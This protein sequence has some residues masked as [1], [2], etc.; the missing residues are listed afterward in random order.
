[1]KYLEQFRFAYKRAFRLSSILNVL[2]I[3]AAVVGLWQTLASAVELRVV[4]STD[5]TTTYRLDMD[6][7]QIVYVECVSAYGGEPTLGYLSNE[8][9]LTCPS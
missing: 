9:A 3:A 4:G 1:M 8:L 7:N 5:S 6:L 2:L